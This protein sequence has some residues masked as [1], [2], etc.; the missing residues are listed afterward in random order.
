[1]K[2]QFSRAT[3]E[4]IARRRADVIGGTGRESTADPPDRQQYALAQARRALAKSQRETRSARLQ[5]ETLT[6]AN[7]QLKSALKQLAQR[8]A[9]ARTFAHFD[10]LT[11]LPNRRLLHDRLR[12]AL[13]QGARL[14]KRVVLLLLDLDDFKSI[15]DRLGHAVGD[16]VLRAVAHRLAAGI[17]AADTACRYGGDEF[18]IMLPAV[19]DT[20]MAVAVSEKLR[21]AL[22]APYVIDNFEIHMS[23]STGKVVYPYEGESSVE[24][25]EKADVA[26][27]REKTTRAK[28]SIMPSS[29]HSNAGRRLAYDLRPQRETWTKCLPG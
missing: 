6:K 16:K 11:G 15:N 21:A 3:H 18:V 25:L 22:S 26:L 13:A 14:H 28:V 20:R 12:Q 2:S 5:I 10:A 23:A 8:E 19:A 1:M 4:I 27:Y 24:L 7:G 29:K 9:Q 17:R